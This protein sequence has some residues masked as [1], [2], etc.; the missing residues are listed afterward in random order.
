MVYH[1]RLMFFFADSVQSWVTVLMVDGWCPI[2]SQCYSCGKCPILSQC[3]SCRK[4]PILCHS[5]RIARGFVRYKGEK[6]T[7]SVH[8]YLSLLWC[9]KRCH[10]TRIAR[11]VPLPVYMN[12]DVYSGFWCT[13]H[14]VVF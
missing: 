8:L 9:P 5:T 11:G 2:L 6:G 10:S 3:S 12:L 4:C 13:S 7:S 1:P 14:C